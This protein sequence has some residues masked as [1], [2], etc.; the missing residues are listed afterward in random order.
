MLH[1]KGSLERA[2]IL[3]LY[4]KMLP[5]IGLERPP[6]LGYIRKC[7]IKEFGRGFSFLGYNRKCYLGSGVRRGLPSPN[8]VRKCYLGG[9]FGQ[10]FHP[11]IL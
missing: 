2:S 9:R 7:S 6:S 8:Y 4:K 10:G 5:R 1:G 3:G 11:W